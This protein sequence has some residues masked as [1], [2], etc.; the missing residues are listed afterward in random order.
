MGLNIAEL[1]NVKEKQHIKHIKSMEKEK[2]NLGKNTRN[3]SPLLNPS[4]VGQS[5]HQR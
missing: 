3:K 4:S 1:P 2:E 5:Q